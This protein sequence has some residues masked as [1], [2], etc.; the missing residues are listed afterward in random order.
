[1]VAPGEVDEDLESETV[2][3]CTKYGEVVRCAIHEVTTEGVSPD[4]A[5]RIFVEFQRSESA[6]KALIDLNGRY[7]G[8]RVVSASFYD[9]DKF[10]NKDLAP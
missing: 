1:M 5:V 10:Y 6:L 3:Q 4:E 8:G 9:E 2:D 7:F